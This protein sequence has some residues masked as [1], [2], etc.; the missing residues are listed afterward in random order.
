MLENGPT[1]GADVVLLDLEDAVEHDDRKRAPDP[2]VAAM[3][4]LG[5]SACSRRRASTASSG[6][7][8][9]ASSSR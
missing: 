7:G 1:L 4:D 8:A 6:T 3:R 5:R 2:I 9:P